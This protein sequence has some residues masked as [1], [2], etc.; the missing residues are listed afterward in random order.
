MDRIKNPFTPGAG[1][2]PPQLAGRNQVIEDGEVVAMR[3]KLQRVERGLV[4]NGQHSQ[5]GDMAFMM[6][7]A[8]G[9]IEEVRLRRRSVSQAGCLFQ[10]TSPCRWGRRI[11]RSQP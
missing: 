3:T 6:R 2:L 1:Y 4:R 5:I 7:Q 11:S 10:G 8:A 9:K